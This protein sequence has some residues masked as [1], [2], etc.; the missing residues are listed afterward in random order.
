VGKEE[1]E[2]SEIGQ[3]AEKIGSTVARIGRVI[4]GLRTVSRDGSSDPMVPADP[5]ALV[6]STL[7]F[8][9]QRLRYFAI[10]TEV[11][12]PAQPLHVLCRPVQISQAILNLLNNAVDA[13]STLPASAE[14]WVRLSV[15]DRGDQVLICVTDSGP[16]VP[17]AVA[18][19]IFRPFFTT[20]GLGSGTGLGLSISRQLVQANGGT[21]SLDGDSKDT[22]F[23][24][25][26]SRP[27]QE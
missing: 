17:S 24:I 7:E 15:E 13:L 8:C 25:W 26:L 27:R 12:A 19:R 6:Q 10:K 23:A 5:V 11:H 3:W 21:L 4:S 1:S 9:E 20:K 22:R 18:N 16:G 14:R 2:V